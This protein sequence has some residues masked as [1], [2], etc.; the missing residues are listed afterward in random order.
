MSANIVTCPQCGRDLLRSAFQVNARL[1]HERLP[2]CKE[3]I[4]TLS[5]SSGPKAADLNRAYRL[6]YQRAYA[7]GKRTGARVKYFLIDPSLGE[8]LGLTYIRLR[9]SIR[10]CGPWRLLPTAESILTMAFGVLAERINIVGRGGGRG[11]RKQKMFRAEASI[12]IENWDAGLG[13]L[14]DAWTLE[15]TTALGKYS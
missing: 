2:W 15:E 4:Q 11:V 8:R 10:I 9:D 7:K 5:A 12:T 14:K 13:V 3:C 1:H 6:A